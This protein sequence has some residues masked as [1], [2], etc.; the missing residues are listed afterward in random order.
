ME[1]QTCGGTDL[2]FFVEFL[3][4]LIGTFVFIF[5]VFIIIVVLVRLEVVVIVII[6]KCRALSSSDGLIYLANALRFKLAPDFDCFVGFTSPNFCFLWR[7]KGSSQVIVGNAVVVWCG[8]TVA[9][10]F[11]SNPP[12]LRLHSVRQFLLGGSNFLGDSSAAP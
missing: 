1:L 7:E 6:V 10:K 4:E 3:V 9:N 12:P 2:F 11:L 5:I 8:Q